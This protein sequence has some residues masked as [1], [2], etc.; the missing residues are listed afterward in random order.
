[1]RDIKMPEETIDAIKPIKGVRGR[2]RKRPK[3]LHADK[4]YLGREAIGV[5]AA[6]HHTAHRAQGHREF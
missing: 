2:P 1:M 5:E 3:K 4:A 6:R